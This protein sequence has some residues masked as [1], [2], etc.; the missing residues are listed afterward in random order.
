MLSTSAVCDRLGVSE[1][2][3]ARLVREGRIRREGRGAFLESDVAAFEAERG[4]PAN[5]APPA[6]HS[7]PDPGEEPSGGRPDFPRP[8]ERLPYGPFSYEARI[9][10]PEIRWIGERLAEGVPPETLFEAFRESDRAVAHPPTA[11]AMRRNVARSPYAP[12]TAG[13]FPPVYFDPHATDPRA[14][15][16]SLPPPDRAAEGPPQPQPAP[17]APRLTMPVNRFGDED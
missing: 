4:S 14:A 8:P 1:S 11:L 3:L 6:P 9:S 13:N 7:L 2:Y 17:R 15:Y 12:P 10:L 16:S 5:P